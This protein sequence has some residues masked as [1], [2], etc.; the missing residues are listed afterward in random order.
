MNSAKPTAR[1]PRST[2]H[3]DAA[4]GEADVIGR[5]AAR[6]PAEEPADRSLEEPV[7]GGG[8]PRDLAA[9][10]GD[11]ADALGGERHA[12]LRCL[13]DPLDEHLRLVAGEDVLPDAIGDLAVDRPP[14]SSPRGAP[15]RATSATASASRPSSISR[16]IARSTAAL[17][18]ARTIASSTATS[19]VRSIPVA[20]AIRP[21]PRAPPSRM[22]PPIGTSGRGRPFESRSAHCG[23]QAT[24]E[25]RRHRIRGSACS[26][27]PPTAS[28]AR[29][30]DLVEVVARACAS[31]SPGLGPG[32]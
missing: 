1:T 25:T 3:R 10:V 6:R 15:R 9:E 30:A 11:Q 12:D 5:L 19:T 18:S 7:D 29:R 2:S 8:G 24:P 28:R 21:T 14:R 31:S 13:G 17:S 16:V 22:R 27:A 23:R 26:A 32:P 4:A 20:P